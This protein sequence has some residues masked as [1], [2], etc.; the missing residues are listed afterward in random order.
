MSVNKQRR[1]K[2]SVR[3]DP[4]VIEVVEHV[5]EPSAGLCRRWSLGQGAIRSREHEHDREPTAAEFD[6]AIKIERAFA[7]SSHRPMLRA[8]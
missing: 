8:P 5:A 3:I 4:E 2:V 7:Q 6:V 1:N